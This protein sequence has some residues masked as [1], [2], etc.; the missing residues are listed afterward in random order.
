MPRKLAYPDADAGVKIESETAGVRIGFDKVE[1]ANN[2]AGLGV[3]AGGA[4]SAE[5]AVWVTDLDIDYERALRAG[6]EALRAPRG[7][8]DGQ[9]RYSWVLDPEGDRSSSC[10]IAERDGGPPIA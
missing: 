4:R 9:L 5:V 6:G 10:S 7:S 8:P 2:I 1:V 3:E